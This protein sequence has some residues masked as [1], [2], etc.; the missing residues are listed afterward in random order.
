MAIS[1]VP[2]H[3]QA[4]SDFLETDNRPTAIFGSDHG[5]SDDPSG[6]DVV[7]RNSAFKSLDL[8]PAAICYI[9]KRCDGDA[10][11]EKDRRQLPSRTIKGKVWTLN[12]IAE[13]W[14]VLI[15]R[16][17]SQDVVDDES[18]SGDYADSPDS[19]IGLDRSST[20]SNGVMEAEHSINWVRFRIAGLSPW[21]EYVRTF[22][23]A[24]TPMG[25][26][27]EWPESLRGYV[28]HIMSNPSPR[29][30]CWGSSM[31]IIYNEACIPLFGEK[32]PHCLGG[33]A[34]VR[35]S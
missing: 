5:S 14:R 30:V 12:P 21:I 18:A 7:Y 26:L 13:K 35:S 28:L 17:Q 20:G 1:D 8:S 27:E 24:S 3:L 4:L 23:W 19:G 22:D 25:P 34:P 9:L 2:A 6:V 15:C 32:H 11:N 29:L 10:S 33:S 16:G 31:T